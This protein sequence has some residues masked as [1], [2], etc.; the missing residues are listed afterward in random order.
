MYEA[1][2]CL[3]EPLQ[4]QNKKYQMTIYFQSD[5]EQQMNTFHFI[6][7]PFESYNLA[8]LRDFPIF[9]QN[10]CIMWIVEAI[11]CGSFAYF[12]HTTTTINMDTYL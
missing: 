12:S 6:F 7:I 9:E 5:C 1:T 3:N 8:E 10:D 2:C 11:S 4:Q